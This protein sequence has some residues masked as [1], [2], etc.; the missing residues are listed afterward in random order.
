MIIVSSFEQAAKAYQQYAPAYVISILDAHEPEPPIFSQIPPDRHL[1]II[2][3]CSRPSVHAD[4][5]SRSAKLIAIADRWRADPAPRGSV[6]VHCHQ[7]VARSMAIAYVL[8]CAVENHES[9]RAIALRM[10]KIAPHADPNIMLISE[11]DL[12][13]GRNDRMVEAILEL[14]PK[15]GAIDEQIVIFPVAA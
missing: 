9:E 4:C 11:A 10:R 5:E 1:K 6:L 2:E 8:M 15:C 12:I 13:M 7:G 3:D 14:G